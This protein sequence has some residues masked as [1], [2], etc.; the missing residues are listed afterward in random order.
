MGQQIER[1]TATVTG[2]IAFLVAHQENVSGHM[3][4]EALVE[5]EE[6]SLSIIEA[7]LELEDEGQP[8]GPAASIEPPEGGASADQARP[9]PGP[10][11]MPAQLIAPAVPHGATFHLNLCTSGPRSAALP[12]QAS[13]VH[14][15]LCGTCDSARFSCPGEW[16]LVEVLHHKSDGAAG[17]AVDRERKDFAILALA[18]SLQLAYSPG[19]VAG[20]PRFIVL[21]PVLDI[22][23]NLPANLPLSIVLSPYH[24]AKAKNERWRRR[25]LSD[26]PEHV[27]ANIHVMRPRQ[28]RQLQVSTVAH[29]HAG[30]CDG[31]CTKCLCCICLSWWEGDENHRLLVCGL[32]FLMVLLICLFVLEVLNSQPNILD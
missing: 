22:D 18:R 20:Q 29:S 21:P 3:A 8:Q 11:A 27:R 31:S 13:M 32:C 30:L 24:L 16:P 2:S 25:R 19:Q 10:A 28:R 14:P 12:V 5:L 15:Q 7:A 17:P 6:I 9:A 4:D 23:V 26:L 1:A